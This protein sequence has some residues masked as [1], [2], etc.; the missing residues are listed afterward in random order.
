MDCLLEVDVISKLSL[1]G[2][3]MEQI[4]LVSAADYGV[5]GHCRE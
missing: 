1:I 3:Q 2:K 5:R 4:P